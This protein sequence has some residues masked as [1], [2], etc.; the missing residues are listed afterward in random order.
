MV[1]GERIQIDHMT[2][3]KKGIC[4][5]HFQAWDRWS[6]FMDADIYSHAKSS[7]AERFLLSLVKKTPFKIESIQV[8]GGS[9]LMAEFEGACAD[10]GILLIVLPPKKPPFNGGVERGNR[11]S[12]EE[13]YNKNNMLADSIGGI[14]AELTKALHKYNTY[15]PHKNL[16]GLTPMEYVQNNLLKAAA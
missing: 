4:V 14:R 7:S 2:V 6:K 1:M 10:L 16:K 13:F 11:I 3:T 8:D 5:K 15:R 9:E 12:R